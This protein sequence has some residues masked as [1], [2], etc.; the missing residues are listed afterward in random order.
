MSTITDTVASVNESTLKALATV[1][2][3]ILAANREA[4]ALVA[5]A[6]AAPSWVPTPEPVVEVDQLVKQVY[7]FQAKTVEANKS[8]ALALVDAWTPKPAA[9]A[10]NS[11]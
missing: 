11:K 2:E 3:Q 7:A 4:A 1:Q 10:S 6:P 5:K 9:K 8:F